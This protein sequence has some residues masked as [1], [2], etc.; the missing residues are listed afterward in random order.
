[1]HIDSHCESS[2][3][4]VT[5]CS[6]HGRLK[7]TETIV[8]LETNHQEASG[9][10]QRKIDPEHHGVR[11]SNEEPNWEGRKQFLDRRAYGRFCTDRS[12]DISDVG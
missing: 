8:Q 7:N 10:S 2:V 5:P 6:S 4:I 9:T 1:M 11:Q 3:E 12:Q